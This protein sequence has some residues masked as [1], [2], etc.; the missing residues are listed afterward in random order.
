MRHYT[1]DDGGP[2]KEQNTPPAEPSCGNQMQCPYGQPQPSGGKGTRALILIMIGI[3]AAFVIGF[4]GYAIVLSVV[5]NVQE[6]A[7]PAQS[8]GSS[9]PEEGSPSAGDDKN[10]NPVGTATDPDFAGLTFANQ[11]S[12]RL[13]AAEAFQVSSQSVAVVGVAVEEETYYSSGIVLTED[14]YLLTAA[15]AIGYSREDGVTVITADG[16]ERKAT[17][18]GFDS[19]WDI[20][21]LK[22]DADH[23]TPAEFAKEASL[24]VGDVVYAVTAAGEDRWNCVLSQGIVSGL[25]RDLS[26]DSVSG[27]GHIQT[28]AAI[29]LNGSGGALVNASGQIVGLTISNEYLG[30]GA[31]YA[32]PIQRAQT[33]IEEMIRNGYVPGKVRLG[34]TGTTI[35]RSEAAAYGVPPGVVILDIQPDSG[36]SGTGVQ[37]GDVMTK[38]AGEPVTEMADVAPILQK[39]KPGEQ[40]EVELYRQEES[41]DGHSFTVTV[42]LKEDLGQTQK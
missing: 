5:D 32:L 1:R 4:G 11:S 17:V 7:P 30:N 18:V 10:S 3:A 42:E 22:V 27:R 8:E 28:D 35:S 14:G 36:F 13:T 12:R 20:A 24:S 19:A 25:D 9:R 16:K 37:I 38:L 23:L 29:S 40:V 33:V 2:A 41:G 26:Y 34:I 6:S 15:H 31:G 21:V 39:H